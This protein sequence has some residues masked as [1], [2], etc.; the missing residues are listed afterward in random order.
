MNEA[1]KGFAN[2]TVERISGGE[3]KFDPTI[4]LVIMQAIAQFIEVCRE[5]QLRRWHRRANSDSERRATRAKEWIV[6]MALT[7]T[8]GDEVAAT[9]LAEEF[10]AAS[11]AE[12]DAAFAE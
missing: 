7:Q 12:L 1:I 3:P 4:I 5:R 10:I 9:A 2:R 6:E 11:D 8:D